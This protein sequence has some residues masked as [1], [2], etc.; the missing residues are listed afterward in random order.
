[1]LDYRNI[2]KNR[3]LRLSIINKLRFIPDERYIKMVYWIKNRKTL[4][5]K[6]PSTFCEKMNW[7]KLHDIHP[8]YT[9]LADKIAVRDYLREKLG[10][11]ICFPL[12][13][14]WEHYDDI[15]FD[16]LPDTF[17][18]KCNHDSGSV[19]I[20]RSKAE[21]DHESLKRFFENRLKINPFNL[22][23]EYPY[24]EIKPYIIA[25]KNMCADGQKDIRDYKFLCFGGEPKYMSVV[26]E[27]SS[28]CRI[29]FFDMDFNHVD[30]TSSHPQ[31]GLQIEKPE[32]FEEM[33]ALV[34][35]LSEG[36]RFVRVDLYELDG[37][38]YFGEFTFFQAGGFWPMKPE[39]WEK[40]LGDM[41][42]ITE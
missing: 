9:Q 20:I 10:E 39:K 2:I 24:R 18:L 22:G 11:D 30:M 34:A 42:D 14:Q 41:I 19:K 8:E 25:E 23:R 27:R 3:E 1:M 6:E 29:D 33:K 13:G 32:K 31:S 35:K 12:L 38:I 26:T 7:L 37:K 15:D 16:A 28:D 36:M 40:E 17:V 4:N 21:M 5:L